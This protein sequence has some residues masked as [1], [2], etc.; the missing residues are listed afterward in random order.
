MTGTYGGIPVRVKAKAVQR[1]RSRVDYYY[2]LQMTPGT[3]G[4]DW[5]LH[6]D[7]GLLGL[8]VGADGWEIKTKDER[9][10]QCLTE[11]GAMNLTRSW[12]QNTSI[13]YSAG[14]GTITY[15]APIR[16][17][18]DL[19]TPEVFKTHLDTLTQLA[20]VTKQTGVT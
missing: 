10:K 14:K 12:S 2:E 9:L 20:N 11:A 4:Q 15:N 5:T 6:Y 8:G 7:Q 19:P 17:L 1:G 3:H 16:S 13:T 18:H